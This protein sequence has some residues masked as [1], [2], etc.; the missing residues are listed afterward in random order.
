VGNS[1]K[2]FLQ[3]KGVFKGKYYPNRDFLSAKKK[4][5]ASETWRAI[6]GGASTGAWVYRCTPNIFAKK[7]STPESWAELVQEYYVGIYT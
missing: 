4:R 6:M 7:K 1:P 2:V 5:L 3:K